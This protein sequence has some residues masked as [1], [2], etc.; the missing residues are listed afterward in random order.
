MARP[1][2][3]AQQLA[4]QLAREIEAGE[5][6]AGS[7]LP[8]ERQLAEHHGY[9]RSTARQAIQQLVEMG[10]V[11]QVP[12]SGARVRGRESSGTDDAHL[13]DGLRQVRDELREIN[14][15]LMAIEARLGQPDAHR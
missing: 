11:E 15:R 1:P 13:D 6:S 4:D 3:K 8:A 7:W 10:F 2:V 12:G 5:I 14:A 9:G